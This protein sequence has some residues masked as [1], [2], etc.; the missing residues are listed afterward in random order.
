MAEES[1][2]ENYLRR[3]VEELGGLMEK[4]VRP[5]KRGAPDD[6]VFWPNG[7]IDIVEIKAPGKRPNHQQVLFHK[8]LK[9]RNHHVVLIDCMQLAEHYIAVSYKML[10]ST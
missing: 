9:D 3:Q 7:T 4:W 2:I 5:G 1:D 6:L 10:C 8:K